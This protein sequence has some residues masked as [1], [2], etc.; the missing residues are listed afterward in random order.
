MKT[1]T[2]ERQLRVQQEEG[3]CSKE[4]LWWVQQEEGGCSKGTITLYLQMWRLLYPNHYI[5][6]KKLLF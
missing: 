2:R 6:L 5:F 4:Q 3:G 1:T